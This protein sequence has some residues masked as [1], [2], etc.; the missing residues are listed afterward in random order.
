MI[1]VDRGD[2]VSPGV[3]AYTVA[4]LGVEGRSKMPLSDACRKLK[5]L[6]PDLC[7]ERIGIWRKGATE[8]SLTCTVEVGAGLRVSEDIHTGPKFRKFVEFPKL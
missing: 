4:G 6:Q 2:E 8:P 1:R 5:S 7:H 3:F